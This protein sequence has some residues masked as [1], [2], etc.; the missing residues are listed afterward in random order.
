M[1]F[2]DGEWINQIKGSS[3]ARQVTETDKIMGK[4]RTNKENKTMEQ[5]TKKKFTKQELRPFS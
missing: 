3:L 2:E 4:N 5:T 1:L